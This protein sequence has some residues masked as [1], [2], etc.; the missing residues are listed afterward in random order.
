MKAQQSHEL[1][2][3]STEA[4]VPF[5]RLMTSHALATEE[6]FKSKISRQNSGSLT[7]M[8]LS[9]EICSL[10]LLL[11]N[12]IEFGISRLAK[13]T[14]Q[15]EEIIHLNFSNKLLH[16]SRDHLHQTVTVKSRYIMSR[17]LKQNCEAEMLL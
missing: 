1:T 11:E 13:S 4:H 16:H 7:I 5:T 14:Q 2:D 17:N 3:S 6:L 9:I 12:E 8:R 10:H 15:I